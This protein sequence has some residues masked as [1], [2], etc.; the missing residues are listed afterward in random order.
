VAPEF[1][2]FGVVQERASQGR[3]GRDIGPYRD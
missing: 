3:R 1:L 2:M